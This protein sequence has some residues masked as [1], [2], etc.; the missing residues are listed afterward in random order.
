MNK[1]VYK[2]MSEYLDR[3]NIEGKAIKKEKRIEL[4]NIKQNDDTIVSILV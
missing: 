1:N 4:R 2:I 3:M